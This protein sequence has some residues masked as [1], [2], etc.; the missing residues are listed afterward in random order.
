MR[1]TNSLIS[2]NFFFK[3]FIYSFMMGGG[4]GVQRHRQREKQAPCQEPHAGLDP[5]TPGSRTPW[6]EGRR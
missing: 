2:T 5:E 3:D 4:G 6:A 1:V